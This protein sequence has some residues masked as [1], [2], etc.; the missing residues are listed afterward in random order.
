MTVN[1]GSVSLRCWWAPTNSVK[2]ARRAVIVLPEIFGLNGWVR[3]VAD[4]LS[5]AG[6]PALA[7]PLFART[8]PELELG[9]DPDSTSEGRRHKEATTNEGILRTFKPRSIGCGRLLKP[10][11]S[12]CASRG[13]GVL[14]WRACGSAGLHPC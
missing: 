2:P 5:A 10:V 3:G 6:V 7:M 11:I 1:T 4:R 14:F 8:A 9:Y 13:G 12:L